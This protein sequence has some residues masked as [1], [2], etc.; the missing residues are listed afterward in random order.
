MPSEDKDHEDLNA[1]SPTE[2]WWV[3]RDSLQER[4]LLQCLARMVRYTLESERLSGKATP[5]DDLEQPR[6]GR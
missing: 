5:T 2:A 6:S 1:A 4:R 3:P